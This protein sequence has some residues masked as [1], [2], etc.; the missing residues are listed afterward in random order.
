MKRLKRYGE[1][2]SVVS[3]KQDELRRSKIQSEFS[4]EEVSEALTDPITL[5]FKIYATS[6]KIQLVDRKDEGD[7]LTK[8]MENNKKDINSVFKQLQNVRI[9]ICKRLTLLLHR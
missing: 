6:K 7:D 9:R 4:K 3:S 2:V 8:L 1:L 5:A